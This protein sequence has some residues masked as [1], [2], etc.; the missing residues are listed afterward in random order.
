MKSFKQTMSK[1]NPLVLIKYGKFLHL[2]QK[3][4][5]CTEVRALLARMRKENADQLEENRILVEKLEKAMEAAEPEDSSED[6]ALAGSG[7]IP[8]S[9]V[10]S[11]DLQRGPTEV[12]IMN[13]ETA[14]PVAA[15]SASHKVAAAAA[16]SRQESEKEAAASE[17]LSD[18]DDA[19]M[20]DYKESKV[21]TG[22]DEEQSTSAGIDNATPLNL[23]HYPFY[24]LGKAGDF[25]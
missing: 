13:S 23:P 21:P 12:N 3:H 7:F 11:R 17:N 6:A 2:T 4:R 15:P 25:M 9:A 14:L 18:G 22:G 19:E 8:I 10:E 24:Y 1:E 16:P 20:Y 5:E